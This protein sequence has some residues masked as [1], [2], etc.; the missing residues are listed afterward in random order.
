MQLIL[1]NAQLNVQILLNIAQYK[2]HFCKLSLVIIL[3]LRIICLE[4][5]IVRLKTISLIKS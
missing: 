4:N 2:V 5:E 1:K 3:N